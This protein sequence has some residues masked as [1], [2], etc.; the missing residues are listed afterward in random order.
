MQKELAASFSKMR[1]W[2]SKDLLE[3]LYANDEGLPE[4]IRSKLPL[5]RVWMV[6]AEQGS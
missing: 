6:T 3:K 1:L 2:S 4:E 5:K